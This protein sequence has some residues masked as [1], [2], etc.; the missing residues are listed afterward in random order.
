MILGIDPGIAT[1]GY[2]VIEIKN[3]QI[4][5]LVYGTI[6]TSSKKSLGERLEVLYSEITEIC[7][8]F[9]IKEAAVEKLYFQ[10]NVKTAMI[11]GQARGV[12]VLAA[13]QNGADIFEYTPNQIKSAI[14]GYGNA[15]K[16]QVQAM[17]KKV[18]GL[19]EIPRPDDAADA[20]ACALCHFNSR[21]LIR[22]INQKR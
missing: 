5:P 18:M 2:G 17:V 4:K 20:L 14:T 10:K 3:N 11:V 1:T 7:K 6:R 21:K 8:E 15:P 13:K 19:K 16:K 12:L 22:K 9:E